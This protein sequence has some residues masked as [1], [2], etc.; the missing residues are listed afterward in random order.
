MGIPLSE[1]SSF[2][3]V[4]DSFSYRTG[5]AKE[6]I[7]HLDLSQG[8]NF[9]NQVKHLK[10]YLNEIIPNRKFIIHQY[11]RQIIKQYKTSVQ[12]VVLACGWDPILVQMSEEFP[13]NSFF[14]VD[15]ESVQVQKK[16]LK[17]IFPEGK[18]SYIQTDITNSQQLIQNL[19]HHGWNPQLP[20][21]LVAEGIICYIPLEKFWNS[22]KTLKKCSNRFFI[23]G[24]FIIDGSK[25]Q[26]SP[27]GYQLIKDIFDL[28]KAEC[29]QNC[30]FYTVEQIKHQLDL[31]GFSNIQFF[32]QDVMQKQ[33]TG[34]VTPWKHSSDG[35]CHC[36]TGEA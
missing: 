20:T 12:T 35:H 34:A 24:D 21:C 4:C 22:V 19:I 25:T 14:G 6:F 23:C 33:R 31:L 29:S 3:L 27:I 5:K 11:I 13:Q 7:S 10:P 16:I 1:T 18:I 32:S 2:V 36:F 26:L 8:W 15:N 9:Y 28:I 30:Y 17:K